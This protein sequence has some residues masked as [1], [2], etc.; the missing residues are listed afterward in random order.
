MRR[1]VTK[2]GRASDARGRSG[3]QGR[4][5]SQ[6]RVGTPERAEARGITAGATADTSL[7]TSGYRPLSIQHPDPSGISG[8]ERSG[9]GGSG[10]GGA[11]AVL[12][13]SRVAPSGGRRPKAAAVAGMATV[14]ALGGTSFAPF[15]AA[16]APARHG[17]DAPSSSAASPDATSTTP[18]AT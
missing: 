3:V 12:D 9:A 13:A 15:A 4:S 17:D 5:G 8:A 1:K 18:T 6:D 11:T 2:G 16:Q 7:R 14:V 10:A